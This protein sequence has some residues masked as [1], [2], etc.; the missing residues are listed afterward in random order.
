VRKDEDRLRDILDA[1]G[2]IR[3]RTGSDRSRFDGDALVRVWCLHHI[4]IIGEAAARVSDELKSKH[5]NPPWRLIVGMRNARSARLLRHGLGSG[6]VG[7][8]A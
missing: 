1:I 4:T 3:S 5:P 7:R 8:R 6:V 2:A